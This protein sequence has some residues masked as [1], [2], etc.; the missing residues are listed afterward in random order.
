MITNHSFLQS[1]P[2]NNIFAQFNNLNFSGDALLGTAGSIVKALLIL[3]IGL[4]LANIIKGVVKSA[5]KKTDIDNK[6]VGW[7]GGD[8]NNQQSNFAVEEWIGEIVGWI[9]TLLVVVAFLDAIDLKVVSEP[10]NA[11]LSEIAQFLPR[12]GGAALLLAVAW[13]LATIAKMLIKKA[14][15]NFKIDERLNSQIQEEKAPEEDFNF[16]DPDTMGFSSTQAVGGTSATSSS[17]GGSNDNISLGDTIGNA[18]YWLI[19]LLFLPNVLSVLRLEGTLRPLEELVN[20]I[21][22][23]IPNIFAAILIA[24]VGWVVARIV[25]KVVTNLLKAS[26]VNSIGA[27]FGIGSTRTTT[28]GSSG[29]STSSQSLAQIIG[30]VAY[31]LVLIPI[32]ITA[33]DALQIAVIS[34]PATE[35]LNQILDLLPKLFSAIVILGLAYVGGHYLSEL[36]SNLLASVGFNN[37]TEWLGVEPNQ[38]KAT[39]TM[40]VDVSSGR[41]TTATSSAA[42]QTPSEII[43]TVVLVVVM[44][45]AALTAV[46]I[47]GI[48]ALEEVV[49]FLLVLAGQVLVGMIIFAI[50]LYFSNLVF[51]LIANSGSSQSNFLAQTARISILV[52]VSAMALERIG[53]APN[54][55]NLAF[56]LLTAGIAV[57]IALAFGLGGRETAGKLVD[58][59]VGKFKRGDVPQ[60]NSPTRR[61]NPN[62]A[63]SPSSGSTGTTGS[64][65]TTRYPSPD[66]TDDLGLGL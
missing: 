15:E 61:N 4:I 19:F 14:F 51:R 31:V 24:A 43:G 30:T 2:L 36:V 64:T 41:S 47:L 59:W 54:I 3:I 35:M 5:L 56:G 49:A 23:I 9:L 1:L 50:G 55:V 22:G 32:A 46:D 13:G 33:L 12:L 6:I 48:E 18:V 39:S 28:V 25:K 40:Q 45:V 16:N 27:R 34:Q 37:V 60:P 8:S 38:S 7:I 44:L 21:L 63:P 52:L 10:L 62:P 29:S 57:A 53:I 20:E 11:L 58:E 42:P 26:G 17:G 65:T 66:D